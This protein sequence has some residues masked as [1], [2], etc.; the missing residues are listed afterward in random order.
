M[1]QG[2]NLYTFLRRFV[3]VFVR[4]ATKTHAKTENFPISNQGYTRSYNT[5]IGVCSIKTISLGYASPL[6]TRIVFCKYSLGD[7][8]YCLLNTRLK[9]FGSLYPTL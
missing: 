7:S 6:V 5:P 2:N 1:Q 4:F 3:T 9:Y 8:P